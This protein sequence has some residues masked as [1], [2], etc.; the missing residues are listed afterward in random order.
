MQGT[1]SGTVTIGLVGVVD[2]I[3][4]A[5]SSITVDSI[6]STFTEYE[7]TFT[8]AQAPTGNNTWQLTFDASLVA[9]SSLWFDLV[10]LFPTT[11]FDRFVG[12]LLS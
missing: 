6:D 10:Q 7:T 5:S 1:Y 12:L 4:Y 2:G 8:S 11:Y 3:V 9:G